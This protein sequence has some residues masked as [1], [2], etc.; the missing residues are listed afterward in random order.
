MEP[1]T[2]GDTSG[3]ECD[4]VFAFPGCTSTP[5]GNPT[6]GTVGNGTAQAGGA[7]AVATVATVHRGRCACVASQLHTS[8]ESL[9]VRSTPRGGSSCAINPSWA[10][11]ELRGYAAPAAAAADRDIKEQASCENNGTLSEKLPDTTGEREPPPSCI[12]AR[13]G[14]EAPGSNAQWQSSGV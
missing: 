11:H 13:H 2:E 10:P 6:V 14:G 9:T 12:A 8:R 7:P 1:K 5:H 3:D 4:R